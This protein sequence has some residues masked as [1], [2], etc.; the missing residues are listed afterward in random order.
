MKTALFALFALVFSLQSI[1]ETL[2][3]EEVEFVSHGT[4]LSGSIVLPAGEIHAAVVFI[5][6]SGKQTRNRSPG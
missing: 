3:T 2:R 4:T 6:G 5:H 1:A